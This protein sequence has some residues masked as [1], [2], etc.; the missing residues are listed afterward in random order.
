MTAVTAQCFLHVWIRQQ[1]LCFDLYVVPERQVTGEDEFLWFFSEMAVGM[2]CLIAL[3]GSCG[4]VWA[5]G[6]DKVRW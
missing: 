1:G 5:P 4:F 6:Q 2:V 3:M